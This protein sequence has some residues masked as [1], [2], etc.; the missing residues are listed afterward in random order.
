M[1]FCDRVGGKITEAIEQDA[2]LVLIEAGMRFS[3]R[4][5]QGQFRRELAQNS[6]GSRLIVDEDAPLAV[7]EDFA[8]KDNFGAF[9][10]DAVVFEDGF[11]AGSGLK[12]AGH[13]GS[14]C[15]VAHHLLGRLSPH[16]QRQGIHENRLSRAGLA[17]EQ[18]QSRAK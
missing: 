3:L 7:G 1:G 2:L 11:G 18:V 6:D 10:V 8:A 13:H 17:G 4:V 15:T 5:H 16:Q 9:R 14:F 12:D